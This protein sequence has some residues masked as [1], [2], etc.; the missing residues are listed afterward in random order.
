MPS[1]QLPFP[2][3]DTRSYRGLVTLSDTTFKDIEGRLFEVEDTVHG[4]GLPVILRCVKNDEGGDITIST[5][6]K[7]LREFATTSDTDWG[8][9]MIEG[10][11]AH[12]VAKP[13]DDYYAETSGLATIPE[14]DLYYVVEDGPC[15]AYSDADANP[16]I[17]AG[18]AVSMDADGAC[19]ISVAGAAV[20]GTATESETISN[21]KFLLMV[22]AGV[23]DSDTAG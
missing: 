13:I 3:G 15:Y 4:T 22:K 23:Q 17:V 8:R 6:K 14:D 7:I 5:A 16:A 12:A 11:N 1:K 9:R 21:T 20:V 10:T 2:R 19:L 18:Q